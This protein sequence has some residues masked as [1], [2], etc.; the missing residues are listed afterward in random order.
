ML[1]PSRQESQVLVAK[2]GYMN[3]S[4]DSFVCVPGSTHQQAS[5]TLRDTQVGENVSIE[6]F[7]SN[8]H[9][10]GQRYL[11]ELPERVT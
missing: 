3:T 5:K 6:T 4:S 7:P 11:A 1:Q 8:V 10:L 2:I 9:W